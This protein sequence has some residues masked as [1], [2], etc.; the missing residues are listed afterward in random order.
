MI[1]RHKTA[2]TYICKVIDFTSNRAVI[3][4]IAHWQDSSYL[5]KEFRINFE[6]W[7]PLPF[8]TYLKLL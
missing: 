8:S 3:L 2:P 5:N 6:M 7:E 1:Y 4:T